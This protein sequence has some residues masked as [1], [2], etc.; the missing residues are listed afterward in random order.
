MTSAPPCEL[1]FV[2]PVY[3]GAATVAGVVKR[4]EEAFDD[5]DHEIVLVNDG[6]GDD[7]ESVC[8]GL[9]RQAGGKIVF[10]QLARNFGEHAA[11]LAGLNNTRGR[12]AVILDD[13][14]QNPPE[15]ARLLYD[16]IRA[17][18]DDVVYGRYRVKRHGLWR[19]LGSWVN[20]RAANWMLKKPPSL[21]LSSFKILNRFLIDEI[22]R[23]R[24][25]FPYIDGLILRATASLGQVDVEHR[26]REGGP[27]NYT[28]RK[29][30]RLW[31][32]MFLNFSI[33]PLRLSAL[34]GVFT[35]VMSLFLLV[36]VVIDKLYI[37]PE[38]TVGLPTVLVTITFFAG[39]QLV[40]LG[41]VG[42]YLG[43]LFMDHSG[44]PQFV[45]RYLRDGSETDE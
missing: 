6:S 44:S 4:I 26:S 43:R 8:R 19:N 2:V 35:S 15:Q 27:S 45:I 1:S 13:D 36:A 24:G 29:L 7:S 11:V 14:G 31:T 40:I 41:T 23:Y 37:N 16:A 25:S 10:L 17:G 38:V 33:A 39:V 5:V 42:E 21:Y 3:N 32:N 30:L 34:L 9:T 18:G 28:L 22:T 20:D 12:Y